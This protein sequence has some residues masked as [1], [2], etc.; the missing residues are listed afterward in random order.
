[1][2]WILGT[3]A[4]VLCAAFFLWQRDSVKVSYVNGL[5]QYNQLPGREFI[6]QRDCFIFKLKDRSSVWPLIGANAPDASASVAELPMEVDEKWIGTETEGVR[7]LDVARVGSRF[8]IV[9][10]RREESRRGTSISFEILFMDEAERRYP[11]LD[12][13]WILDHT[14]ELHGAAPFILP[15]YAAARVKG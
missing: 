4:L 10:V 7:I 1:M 12:A 14:P 9:S 2:K 15:D 3:C 5:P 13:Y 11:R 8:K 6:L